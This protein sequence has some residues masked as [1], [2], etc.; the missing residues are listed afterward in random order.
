MAKST[1]ATTALNLHNLFGETTKTAPDSLTAYDWIVINSSGGKD[2]QAMLDEVC[3]RAEAEGVLSRVVVVHADLGRVEWQGTR[4][5]AQAQ[6]ASYGVKWRVVKRKQDLLAHIEARKEKLVADGKADTPAWPSSEARYCTSDHK[7]AQIHT[8]FTSLVT[9]TRLDRGQGRYM[10]PGE[11]Q[12]RILNCLG[13]RAEESPR[14]SKMKPMEPDTAASNGKREV[15][16]WLPLH[17]W[18][19]TQVWERLHSCRSKEHIHYAYALGMPRVSCC[20][21]IFAPREA[22]II[23]GRHNPELLA[24]Y[25]RVEEKIGHKFRQNLTMAQVKAAVDAGEVPQEVPTWTM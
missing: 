9:E 14:R 25:V 16:R 18:T 5:I 21:C 2:S 19:E 11:A 13:M 1:P 23:A 7:R 10:M 20:F 17:S 24:E 15:T 4:E 22:L 6:A 12:V 3:Q 8:L